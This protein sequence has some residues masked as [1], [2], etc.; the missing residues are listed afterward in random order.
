MII[1]QIK[2]TLI[3]WANRNGA[4]FGYHLNEDANVMAIMGVI[5]FIIFAIIG[6]VILSESNRAMI[7][8]FNRT[9]GASIPEGVPAISGY[10]WNKTFMDLTVTENSGYN[11]LMVAVIVIAAAVIIGIL[12][13]SFIRGRQQ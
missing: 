1:I 12:L 7:T 8:F 13:T 4:P 3:D 2:K 9:S 10:G 11:L 6:V 5:L